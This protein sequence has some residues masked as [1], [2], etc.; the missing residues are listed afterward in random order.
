MRAEAV[1]QRGV[2]DVPV[3]VSGAGHDG[4]AMANLTQV[5]I[6]VRKTEA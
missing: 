3:L 1:V 5:M 2:S 6:V 4:L